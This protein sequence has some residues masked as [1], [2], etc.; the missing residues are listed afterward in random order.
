MLPGQRNCF[1]LD[2]V[3]AIIC[4]EQEIDPL[5]FNKELTRSLQ[6]CLA[7]QENLRMVK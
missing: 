1:Q 5:P 6:N 3:L 2:D 7:W 4:A